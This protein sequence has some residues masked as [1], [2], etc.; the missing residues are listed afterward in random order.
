MAMNDM[1]TYRLSRGLSQAKLAEQAGVGKS[2]ISRI[3]NGQRVPSLS[4][5]IRLHE[6]IDVPMSALQRESEAVE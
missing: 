3:E 2:M 6:L 4:L 5:A 1:R